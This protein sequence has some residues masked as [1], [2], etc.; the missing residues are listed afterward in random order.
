MTDRAWGSAFC[1]T[2]D[3]VFAL[4]FAISNVVEALE[5]RDV[6]VIGR[7]LRILE[8]RAGGRAASPRPGG[9]TG[10]RLQPDA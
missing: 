10:I 4:E 8:T 2:Q 3:T 7:G 6:R 1:A 5:G 9:Q